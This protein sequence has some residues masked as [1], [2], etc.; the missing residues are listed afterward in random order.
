[1]D[2]KTIVTKIRELMKNNN[3]DTYI[4]TKFDPHQSEYTTPHY[5]T[6]NFVSNFSGSNGTIVITQETAGLWTDGRYFIQANKQLDSDVFTLFKEGIS[7]TINYLDFAYN[8][9]K[10]NGVIGINGET[11]SI[12]NINNLT[13]K[14]STKNITLNIDLD[15][16]DE[17]WTGRPPQNNN[18]VF[19]HKIEFAGKSRIEK[20]KEIR[21]ELKKGN[22]DMTVVNV[23]EDI[24]WIYNLRGTDGSNTPIFDA[25]TVITNDEA[26][27]FIDDS[28]I[29]DVK[30]LLINDNI[31]IKD[32]NDIYDFLKLVDKSTN[33]YIKPT[34]LNYKLFN[35][36]KHTNVT[37]GTV[38]LS[39]KLKAC[40][41]SIEI[42]N[43]KKSTI[44]DNVALLRAIKE[45]K[46]TIALGEKTLTEYDIN[47]I[48][49]KYRK[50]GENYLMPSFNT[51][52]AYMSNGAMLHYSANKDD[53]AVIKNSGFLLID[54]GAQ[55]L[56]GTTDITRTISLG[57]L[58]DEMKKDFTL[59]LKSVIAVSVARFLHG[60]PGYKLD[61]LARVPMWNEG[62]DY[63]CGTGH[64]L[65]YCL[66]V[67]EGP[68]N[69][70]L[71]G[72]TIPLEEGMLI[73]NE[74]GVYKEDKYGIRTENTLVVV[75]DFK[76]DINTFLKFE[77]VNFFP[78]DVDAIEKSLLTPDELTWINNYHTET[79]EKLSPYLNNE[80]K[81]W[82]KKETRLI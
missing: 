28:K 58:T 15:F 21:E 10:P 79:Y 18:P 11:I 47:D 81:E 26:I 32:Y 74:P 35:N 76:D 71:T 56:D 73:T 36:I 42:E 31:V 33:V 38:N 69:M 44:R 57:N 23:L 2:T 34:T 53:C 4:V 24:A 55:Y 48:L 72:D 43:I 17:V 68:H 65:G 50:Q 63:K 78:I 66:N 45:I 1:M 46:E 7:N 3:I 77:T 29:S 9:T 61:M 80:E 52:G 19:E 41:N 16:V 40:K 22:W 82:L 59:T 27:L 37:K 5:D 14:I 8:N 60:T 62:L 51:I 25:Y 30:E 70:R 39:E 12:A 20:I 75:E 13:E 49:T 64:G 54:S 6:V 67:H